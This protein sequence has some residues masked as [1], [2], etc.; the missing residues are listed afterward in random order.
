[1][2]YSGPQ[3]F[4]N[5]FIVLKSIFSVLLCSIRVMFSLEVIILYYWGQT[6]PSTLPAS[7]NL[8]SFTLQLSGTGTFWLC[9]SGGDCF[10]WGWF[11]PQSQ[12]LHHMYMLINILLNLR[13]DPVQF[14]RLLFPCD[15]SFSLLSF[16]L[17]L[18]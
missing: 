14:S 18:C 2:F 12:L 6:L 8:Q 16:E 13:V 15:S 11:L 3:L 9:V 10:F 4:E 17:Q 7:H 1:M 5:I